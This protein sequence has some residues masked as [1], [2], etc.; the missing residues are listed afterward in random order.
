MI[1]HTGYD[2][3][4]R[5]RFRITAIDTETHTV[6]LQYD[7]TAWLPGHTPTNRL[8]W[9]EFLEQLIRGHLE[10]RPAD[11]HR[12]LSPRSTALAFRLRD[13]NAGLGFT[14]RSRILMQAHAPIGINAGSHPFGS[15]ALCR[16]WYPG[17]MIMVE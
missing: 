5:S 11:E 3:R 15:A 9:T 2:H 16:L 13:I 6:T 8:P 14:A 7:E 12:S 17:T 4:S 10:I 1:K